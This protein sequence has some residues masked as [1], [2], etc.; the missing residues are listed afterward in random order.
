MEKVFSRIWNGTN[1]DLVDVRYGIV[2]CQKH[3]FGNMH[4]VLR[5]Q[6]DNLWVMRIPAT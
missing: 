2:Q 5:K 1:S 6:V 4:R 3:T